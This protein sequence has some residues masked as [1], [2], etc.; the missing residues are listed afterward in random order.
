MLEKKKKDSHHF[1]QG[2]MQSMS[3]SVDRGVTPQSYICE[4]ICATNLK[5][6]VTNTLTRGLIQW[7]L[8]NAPLSLDRV[9]SKHHEDVLSQQMGCVYTLYQ[10]PF[11]NTLPLSNTVSELSLYQTPILNTLPLSNTVSKHFLDTFLKE[12]GGTYPGFEASS[13]RERYTEHYDMQ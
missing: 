7:P 10:T 9:Q 13:D 5:T 4:T 12:K 2:V 1:E 11:L 3:R 8:S 6:L